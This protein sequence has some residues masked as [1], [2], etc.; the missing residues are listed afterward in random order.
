M[1]KDQRPDTGSEIGQRE[2]RGKGGEETWGSEKRM[3]SMIHMGAGGC[4]RH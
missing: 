4:T 1:A 2:Q 3:Y